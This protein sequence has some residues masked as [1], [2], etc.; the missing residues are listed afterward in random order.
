[1]NFSYSLHQEPLP[2]Q[3]VR[4]LSREQL[5]RD[6][7]AAE[8]ARQDALDAA[9]INHGLHNH[10]AYQPIRREY[11]AAVKLANER[12]AA[13][14]YYM[15]VRYAEPGLVEVKKPTYRDQRSHASIMAARV[16]SEQGFILS[17][18]PFQPY[19]QHAE[20]WL[21]DHA[22]EIEAP[23][24]APVKYVDRDEWTVSLQRKYLDKLAR[25]AA[26]QDG[27]RFDGSW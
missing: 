27:L 17:P 11:D 19:Q 16:H 4:R 18:E 22:D 5:E 23:K 20:R 10:P 21:A 8:T 25:A 6:L 13:R 1:M 12:H 3:N 26:E 15:R 14:V 24:P 2:L 7:Q 9:E